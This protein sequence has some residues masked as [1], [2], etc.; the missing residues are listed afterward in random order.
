MRIGKNSWHYRLWLESSGQQKSVGVTNLCSYCWIVGRRVFDKTKTWAEIATAVV[1]MVI[2]F[3]ILILA[4]SL[5][6]TNGVPGVIHLAQGQLDSASVA[7][8]IGTSTVLIIL[9]ITFV[10]LFVRYVWKPLASGLDCS[11]P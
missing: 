9:A 7:D 10:V 3:V 11:T 5:A 2:A 4:G 6:I 8:G 1:P